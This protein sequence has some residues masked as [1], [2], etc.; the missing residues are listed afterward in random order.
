MT[1]EILISFA[2]GFVAGAV[3][4]RIFFA[5]VAAAVTADVAQLKSDVAT[6]KGKAEAEV[7]KL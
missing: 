3:L 5:K 2:V 6:L 4:Y 7:K 1:K